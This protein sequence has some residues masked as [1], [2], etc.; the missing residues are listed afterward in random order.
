MTT[1]PRFFG[2]SLDNRP[3]SSFAELENLV[4][5]V[6]APAQPWV[7]E[8]KTKKPAAAPAR[9]AKQ[10]TEVTIRPCDRPVAAPEG[11]DMVEFYASLTTP[12]SKHKFSPSARLLVQ[13]AALPLSCRRSVPADPLDPRRPSDVSSLH[14]LANRWPST[15]SRDLLAKLR[16]ALLLQA[17][18]HAAALPQ[19]PRV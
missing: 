5:S 18:L 17:R 13:G 11:A 15:D 6:P 19:E 10:P 4:S 1:F 14:P 16:L 3:R 2:T 9:P 8:V 7:G 12:T